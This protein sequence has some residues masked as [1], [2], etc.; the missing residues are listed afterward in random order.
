MLCGYKRISHKYSSC[1]VRRKAK[2]DEKHANAT[3][4]NGYEESAKK[5]ILVEVLLWLSVKLLWDMDFEPDND[6]ML[7]AMIEYFR[8]R[9]NGKENERPVQNKIN[10]KWKEIILK[11]GLDKLY[12]LEQV[13]F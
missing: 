9:A 1:I 5:N 12:W 11:G 8:K 7:R 4:K 6:Q 3:K 10:K 2:E 13:F